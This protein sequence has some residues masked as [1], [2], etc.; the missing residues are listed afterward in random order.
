M[1]EPDRSQS[2]NADQA[3]QPARAAA[4]VHF[5]RLLN[6]AI[7][8]GDENAYSSAWL[9]IQCARIPGAATG[10]ILLCPSAG[11]TPVLSATWPE[12]NL[13]LPELSSVAHRAH[14]ERRTVVALG[15]MGPASSP[16]QPV[17]LLVGVPLGGGD[18]P[19]AV[20]AVAL[21][22]TGGTTLISPE[23]VTER[24]Q[25]GAGWLEALSQAR[26]SKELSSNVAQAA[27][28]LDLLAVVAHQPNLQATAMAIVNN[29]ATQ[30]DC[31]RVS[32]GLVKRN[33][34]V[35]VRA[36]SHSATFKSEARLVD[37]IANVMEEAIDQ[38]ASVIF[39][40]L[41]GSRV[42]AMAHRTLVETIKAPAP[43]AASVI[44]VDGQGR[45][46]GAVTLERH[47]ASPIDGKWLQRAEAVAALIGPVIGLQLRN[48]KLFAGRI[49]NGLSEGVVKLTGPRRPALR[50]A[51][52]AVAVLAA[53]LLFV[54][55]EHRVTAKSVLEGE[56]QRAVVAPFE[57]FIQAAPIRAGDTVKAGAVLAMLDDRELVLERQ[58]WRAERDKLIQ[59]QREV[60]AKHDRT[61]LVILDSQIRQ[62]EAQLNLAEEK[63]AR[64]RLVAP[65]DGIVTSGDFSQKLG[66]PVE[67]G[68][69]LFEVAPLDSYRLIVHVDERDVR[70]VVVGQRGT[71]A[72]AGI[73]WTPLPLGVTKITPVT[74]AEEGRNSFQIEAR[75]LEPAA[76]LRPGMEGV[77]KIETGQRSIVW[78]WTRATLEWVRLA[79]WKYL[80]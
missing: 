70:Y 12:R 60:L 68:K 6:E 24:M 20:A 46:I 17:G 21:T 2:V 52:L 27:S 51:V 67:K 4:D 62:A 44:L 47:G 18:D 25:W 36:I 53:A 43:S 78:I 16:A 65:F 29:L 8:S 15:R 73:P 10:L 74:V 23:S 54:E 33:G 39:P 42:I 80:P 22:I 59:K 13:E 3:P 31:D 76:G 1:S 19:V 79:A 35:R 32:L 38:S 9:A 28:C 58:K 41:A 48:N 71:V 57:G 66:S 37:S 30:F 75:L 63:L 14:S 49:V 50:L 69:L 56:V 55:G 26:Q 7:S 40:A 45:S 5:D 34:S 64:S 61:N 72:L 11:Q 77:A